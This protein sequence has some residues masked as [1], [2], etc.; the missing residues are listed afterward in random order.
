[1]RENEHA[2]LAF[3]WSKER[4]FG[5]WPDVSLIDQY[6]YPFVPRGENILEIN[7]TLQQLMAF[8]APQPYQQFLP[9]RQAWKVT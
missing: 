2:I 5:A 8:Q 7:S 9:L 3:M 4:G 1:M 6:L